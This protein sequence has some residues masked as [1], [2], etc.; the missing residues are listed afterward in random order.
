[1]SNITILKSDILQIHLQWKF[2]LAL[3]HKPQTQIMLLPLTQPWLYVLQCWSNN[4]SFPA[5]THMGWGRCGMDWSSGKPFDTVQ[6][7]ADRLEGTWLHH[8][9]QNAWWSQT[10]VA[11]IQRQLHQTLS[12]S[13]NP[14]NDA[15]KLLNQI[16]PLASSQVIW[17]SSAHSVGLLLS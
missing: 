9:S 13:F 16:K 15:P 7:D 14:Q 5:L 17:A 6:T 1:M 11:V 3:R 4:H 8:S 2:Q 10:S 12:K